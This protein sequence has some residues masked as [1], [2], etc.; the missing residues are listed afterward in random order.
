M[1]GLTQ[2]QPVA[3]EMDAL[4]GGVGAHDELVAARCLEGRRVVPQPDGERA[5]TL[6]QGADQVELL[7][8]A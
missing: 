7:A 4:D 8:L 3:P 5:P 1:A 2:R 6:R